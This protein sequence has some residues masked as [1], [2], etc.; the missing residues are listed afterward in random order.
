[1]RIN[2]RY[3]DG[4]R[5]GFTRAVEVSTNG[6]ETSYKLEIDTT[7]ST[8]SGPGKYGYRLRMEDHSTNVI[9]YPADGGWIEFVVA[10]TAADVVTAA[11]TEIASIISDA[12]Q[13]DVNL[14]AK[15][16]RHGF[17]DCVGGCDG[18]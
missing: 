3:P 13:E 12:F 4:T 18:W 16:V 11:R 14:A 1:M 6:D 17:H 15:F 9:E 2:V 5:A 7:T 8:G 10:D